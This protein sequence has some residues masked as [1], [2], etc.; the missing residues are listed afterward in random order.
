MRQVWVLLLLLVG[1]AGTSPASEGQVS[2]RGETAV[3]EASAL[4][5]LPALRWQV[6]IGPGLK[7]PAQVAG[8]HVVVATDTAVIALNP[9]TGAE[10]WRMP[11]AAGVWRRSLAASGDQI[12]VGVPG[13]ALALNAVTGE[14]LWRQPVT[15]ELLWPA[16]ITEETILL[17]TAFVGPD[18][19]PVADG[20]AWVYALDAA[21]GAVLWAHET[22]AYTLITPVAANGLVGV[23]GSMLGDSAVK[24]GGHLRLHLYDLA[25]GALRWSVDREDGFVKTLAMDEQ[26]LYFLAYTDVLY[27]L[28]LADGSVAWQYPTEN[29]S[30][31]FGF[32]REEEAVYF[33]SDNAFVHKVDGASG[34]AVWRQ[35]LEGVFNA[36]RSPVVLAG[37]SLYFQGNDNRLYA[38]DRANGAVLWQTEP[39]TRSLFAPTLGLGHLFLVGSD[40][41]LYAYGPPD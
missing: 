21:T 22:A 36:P 13:Y 5:S 28:S 25:S 20:L 33:G 16:F 11:S 40:G 23:A 4:D 1:C 37:D 9:A 7:A 8:G 2:E 30:P 24:E 27:G 12:V 26:S 15:G 18:A 6:A 35:P 38:L 41:V 10:S 31:G 17:G 32:S 19:P 29:W 14:E 34:T 39:Q 3:A